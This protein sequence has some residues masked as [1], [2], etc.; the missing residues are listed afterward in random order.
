MTARSS[1]GGRRFSA[2]TYRD[3]VMAPPI[4]T[5]VITPT[6][7]SVIC[8][9]P[10]S[11]SWL[12]CGLLASTGVAGRPHEWFADPIEQRNRD[13][14]GVD[15]F[16]EYL[17]HVRRAATTPNGVAALKVMWATHVQLL[18]RLRE[19]DG[20]AGGAG[21]RELLERVFPRPR[22]VWLVREDVEAQAA[23]WAR[24]LRTGVWSDWGD[25]ARVPARQAES[26][27]AIAAGLRKSN[28]AWSAWFRAHSVEPH[29]ARYE[30]LVADPEGVAASVLRFLGVPGAPRA[31]VLTART[32][33]SARFE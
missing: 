1:A 2:D 25:G 15:G 20:G 21:D 28:E 27:G 8:T 19:P 12:L 29:I 13:R 4:P 33:R 11:G 10:R 9:T 30:E 26:P 31:T 14:W 22:Y 24:A 6:A 32:P 18:D 17:E 3:W 23:S 5:E 16:G 7:S